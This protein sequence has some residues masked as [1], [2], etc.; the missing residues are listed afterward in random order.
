MNAAADVVV[1]KP[2]APRRLDG[3]ERSII[4]SEL[5]L[6]GEWWEQNPI[7]GYPSASALVAFIEGAGGR[8]LGSRELHKGM[9]NAVYWI[10]QRWL[11]LESCFQVVIWLHF[12]PRVDQETGRCRSDEENAQLLDISVDA[13]RMRLT[14]ARYAYIGVPC[15]L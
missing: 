3:R 15:P 12:V 6:W 1:S 8:R 13:Y 14:R 11:Q 4:D 9:P 5:E 10:H 7:N 2:R